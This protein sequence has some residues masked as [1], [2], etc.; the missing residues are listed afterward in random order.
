VAA[1]TA[2]ALSLVLG[3]TVAL[4]AP[5][6]ADTSTPPVVKAT[7]FWNE[8]TLTTPVTTLPTL[9]AEADAASGVPSGDLGVG[10]VTE[11]LGARDK[12]AAL[13]FDLTAIPEGALF[14]S[15]TITVPVDSA[16]T[17]VGTPAVSA[18]EN[19][20]VFAE[21]PAPQD[22][23]KAPP[24]AAPTCVKGGLNPAGA[25]VFDLT[26]MANDWSQGTPAAG[27]SLVP[28]PG[29]EPFSVAL[30]GKN[31]ITTKA[32]WSPPV[33]EEQPVVA[34]VTP[35]VPGVAPPPALSGGQTPVVPDVQVPQ[36]A[37]Q[38]PTPQ[39]NPAPQ[40]VAIRPTAF[41]PRSLVPSTQW[42]L[43]VLA[44]AGLLTLAWIT[45][46]DPLEPVKVDPRRARFARA[47]RSA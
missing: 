18:C 17:N 3:P 35:V 8:K 46:N 45:Q 21:A 33:A 20:D 43:A 10:Y 44:V 31:G 14:S 41:A 27:V 9:P 25:F 6:H 16:G 1:R 7:W 29:A 38:V 13:D 4:A 15:F 12:V 24:Y 28:T 47:V 36:T 39:A 5:A 30:K 42:W 32:S 22:I 19:I 2:V 37:P 40:A 26:T 34:P 23:T 11:Q